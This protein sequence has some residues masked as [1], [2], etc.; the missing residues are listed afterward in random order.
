MRSILSL[1]PA[2]LAD[3]TFSQIIAMA[4]TVTHEKDIDYLADFVALL[5]S[6]LPKMDREKRDGAEAVH[7][8]LRELLHGVRLGC[9]S[10]KFKLN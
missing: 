1:S 5:G 9:S 6:A 2:Q 7:V 3:K 8:L 4:Y 10:W